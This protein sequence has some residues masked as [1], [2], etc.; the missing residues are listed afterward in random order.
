MLP[1][2]HRATYIK[3]ED[4]KMAKRKAIND[5]E[6]DNIVGGIGTNNTLQNYTV[7]EGLAKPEYK[8]ADLIGNMTS[9]LVDTNGKLKTK[10]RF[11]EKPLTA[12]QA[13]KNVKK[14]SKLPKSIQDALKFANKE[15]NII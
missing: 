5:E 8:A 7:S 11:G 13:K 1:K 2:T 4:Y 12:N 14:N 3:K 10:S 9:N 15:D 6:M